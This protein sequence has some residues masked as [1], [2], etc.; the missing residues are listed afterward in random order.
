[1]SASIIASFNPAYFEA[2]SFDYITGNLLFPKPGPVSINN[3]AGTAAIYMQASLATTGKQDVAILT[4]RNKAAFPPTQMIKFAAESAVYELNS[5]LNALVGTVPATIYSV[6][7]PVTSPRPL[8]PTPTVASCG[9]STI[10]SFRVDTPCGNNV[11]NSFRTMDVTC[12]NGYAERGGGD[13]SCKPLEDWS[14]YAAT[15][16]KQRTGCVPSPTPISTVK[17]VGQCK[18]DL[19][20]TSYPYGRSCIGMD[21][22]CYVCGANGQFYVSATACSK[23]TPTST[24]FYK[25]TPTAYPKLTPTITTYPRYTPT[26]SPK[27]LF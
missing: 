25:V 4:L 14:V 2:V 23:P 7:T 11:T 5:T 1:V 3:T 16:C 15:I 8:T 26:P 24:P 10:R 21:A 27:P 17:C 22:L 13:T 20:G 18:G 6:P 9:L 19:P 12:M